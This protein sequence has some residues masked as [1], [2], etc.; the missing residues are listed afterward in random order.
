[1][2]RLDKAGTKEIEELNELWLQYWH[3][4]SGFS[5]KRPAEQ[6]LIVIREWLD[7]EE[8]RE[9]KKAIK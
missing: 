3:L 7:R 2:K 8:K 1:M 9:Q 6:W 4:K 5:S